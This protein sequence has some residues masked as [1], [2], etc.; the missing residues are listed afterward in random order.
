MELVEPR[1]AR[2]RANDTTPTA[3]HIP[4]ITTSAT[5]VKLL[6]LPSLRGL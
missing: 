1:S 4:T 3:N 6:D 2:R 5:I